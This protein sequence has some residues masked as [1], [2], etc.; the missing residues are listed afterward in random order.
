MST[1]DLNA[2]I[3]VHEGDDQKNDMEKA[4][5]I[6]AKGDQQEGKTDE[7][8]DTGVNKSS[9]EEKD[10]DDTDENAHQY[11]ELFGM[12]TDKA[13]RLTISMINDKHPDVLSST[14]LDSTVGADA[15]QDGKM[16]H[17]T[18][19]KK[20][21]EEISVGEQPSVVTSQ[22]QVTLSAGQSQVI[23][24]TQSSSYVKFGKFS[25]ETPVPN[26]QIDFEAWE[27][28]VVR[29]IE[30][31]PMDD[32]I[33]AMQQSLMKPARGLV[34]T[35]LEASDGKGVLSRLQ[36]AYGVVFDKHQ[37]RKDLYNMVQRSKESASEFLN[38]LFL[39]LEK[40]QQAHAVPKEEAA[41][42]MLKQFNAG[43]TDDRL[44][45]YLRLEEKES[46]P[47]D[48]GTLL[49]DI[50]NHES[51]HRGRQLLAKFVK[52]QA[53][54]SHAETTATKDLGLSEEVKDL[55]QEITRLKHIA[56]GSAGQKPNPQNV[57]ARCAMQADQKQCKSSPDIA[58]ELSQIKQDLS[59]LNQQVIAGVPAAGAAGKS[60]SLQ[61]AARKER[62]RFCFRCGDFS[63]LI[64]GCKNPAD[65]E[66]V[67]RRFQE[68]RPKPQG[69]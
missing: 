40:C 30:K 65:P 47:P 11:L 55:R 9:I 1:T 23:I 25:G 57:Q 5:V 61:G 15:G 48:F 52:S 41:L 27:S 45:D 16:D 54:Q 20:R 38:R 18:R 49:S 21:I 36:S 26:G 7:K 68:H 44:V 33:N 69:N 66:L 53:I 22:G 42:E 24:Q 12:M 63:H 58:E 14:R 8:G 4:E 51:K 56:S 67:T 28:A 62:K 50:R 31:K 19:T 2:D 59:R 32:V 10:E 13:R 37:L 29:A 43:C 17:S 64:Y 6:Q 60:P 3:I 39:H 35:L 34:K 46:D